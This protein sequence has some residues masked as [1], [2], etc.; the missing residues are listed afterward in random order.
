[1]EFSHDGKLLSTTGMSDYVELWNVSDRSRALSMS[2]PGTTF[3][4]RFSPDDTLL[5]IP[6]F[7]HFAEV[8][9]AA[10]GSVVSTLDGHESS[11]YDAMFSPD[12]SEIVTAG[13]D[14]TVRIWDTATGAMLQVLPKRPEQPYLNRALW[15]DPTHL[16]AGYGDGVLKLWVRGADGMFASDCEQSLGATPTG[17]L[18]GLAIS[19]DHHEIR[20]AGLSD[21]GDGAGLW[22]LR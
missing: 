2:Y 19:P 18:P 4:A 8:R 22:T 6:T 5:V 12:G 10:D 17:Q 15:Y 20:A 14:G 13:S 9:S 21:S 16:L 3:G 11:V 7:R 1:V